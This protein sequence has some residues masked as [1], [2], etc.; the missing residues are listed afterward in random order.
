M[1]TDGVRFVSAVVAS[2]ELREWVRHGKL[3]SLFESDGELLLHSFVQDYIND[4]GA[5]PPASLV[6]DETGITLVEV[7]GAAGYYFDKLVDRHIVTILKNAADAANVALKGVK[8]PQKAL[9]LMTEAVMSLKMG[10]GPH[11]VTDFRTAFQRIYHDDYLAKLSGEVSKGISLGWET[12]DKL[13]GGLYGGDVVSIVGRPATGKSFMTL[14]SAHSMWKTLEEPMAFF[15][16]EMPGLSMEQRLAAMEAGIPL[17]PIKLAVSMPKDHHDRFRD[18]LDDIQGFAAPFH[19]VDGKMASTV[20][21]IHMFCSSLGVK[22]AFIDGAYLLRH[23]NPRLDRYQRVAE[24]VDLIKRMSVDLDIPVVCSWQLNRDAAKK[25]K[26][27][28]GDAELGLEDIGYSDAIGQHS[29]VVLA[30]L[31]DES[32]NTLQSRRVR[33]LKGR[34]GETGEFTIKW[35]FMRTQFSEIQEEAVE[36]LQLD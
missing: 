35:D 26:K 12:L 36:D 15:T 17:N 2:G 8:D 33:V 16:E 28:D 32:I 21:D 10:T 31:Q 1:S 30:L 24:N 13:G 19:M 11:A 23:P 7:E 3:V 4:Y 9:D 20:Q 27:G 14:W 6:V 25:H 22:A 34:N 18:A 5:V 29:T